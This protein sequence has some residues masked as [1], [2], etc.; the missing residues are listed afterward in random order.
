MDENKVKD[1]NI[2]L[3]T[4]KGGRELKAVA[5]IDKS[6]NMKMVEANRGSASRFLVFDR[7]KGSELASIMSNFMKQ[8]SNPENFQLFQVRAGKF[9]KLKEGLN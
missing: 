8:E 6:G 5:S 4:E 2:L 1:Q 7:N 3:V 9:E